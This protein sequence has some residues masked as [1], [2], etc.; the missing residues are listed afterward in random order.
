[1]K[2]SI[3][4]ILT[5]LESLY[6]YDDSCFLNYDKDQS[7]QLLFATILSA[8]CTDACVNIVTATLFKQFPTLESFAEADIGEIEK[9]IRPTGFFRMKAK[10]LQNSAG[11]L[12]MEFGGVVPSDME[13]LT[14]LSGVGRKTANVVRCHVFSIP[15]ITVDTHVGRV[16]KRLGLTENTDPVKAEFD[17]MKILPQKSWMAYNQQI[18]NHGRQVCASRN[19]KCGECL[20]KANCRHFKISTY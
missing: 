19:P 1:M 14:S 20:L 17:L 3:K 7:W 5:N 18:I 9:I 12:L 11:K 10:H 8:Q 2:P 6:P 13:S 4:R 15:S 16:S